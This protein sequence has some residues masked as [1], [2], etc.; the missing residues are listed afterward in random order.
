MRNLAERPDREA[1]VV[2][3]VIEESITF[4]YEDW[5]TKWGR[6]LTRQFHPATTGS[7][8]GVC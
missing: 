5:S 4:G 6:S 7:Q 1:E 8:S 3:E 2:A